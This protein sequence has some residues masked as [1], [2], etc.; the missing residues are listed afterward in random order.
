MYYITTKKLTIG[1]ARKINIT[2]NDGKIV[3]N[4]Q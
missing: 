2:E 4:I 1:K 3:Y